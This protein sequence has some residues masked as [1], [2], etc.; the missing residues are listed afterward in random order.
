M[1]DDVHIVLTNDDQPDALLLERLVG[2]A[3][4]VV[5]N[6][7]VPSGTFRRTLGYRPRLLRSW[8]TRIVAI[9]S[10]VKPDLV[11]CYGANLNAYA[12]SEIKRQLGIPY[13]V[14]LHI[15][16]DE[17]VRGRAKGARNRLQLHALRALERHA[18]RRADLVLPVY[19]PIVPYLQ[20][21]GVTRYR[22]AY[23]VLN[24][25]H[26]RR[27]SEYSL[28]DPVRVISVGRQFAAK[29]PEQLMRAVGSLPN[30]QLTL[31]GDGPFHER[32]KRTAEATGAPQQF[33]FHRGLL[34]DELCE[35]L[36]GQDV[37]ATHSDFWELSKSVI[38]A[39][40][41]GLPVLLNR[42]SGAPVPE[43]TP[44]IASLVED[45]PDS[46]ARALTTLIEDA[47]IREQLGR[48]GAA[49]AWRRWAPEATEAAFVEI[50]RGL[51]SATVGED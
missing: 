10:A 4:V 3:R 7:P 47:E 14:S 26:L 1:F 48:R 2:R 8:A 15:N 19:E 23:N 39:V 51:L 35:L 34:N 11:R 45:R 28:H 43:L 17:D 24:G 38:E 40:L 20:R 50:Y 5:H 44:E 27:K 6:S 30:V 49:V 33:V 41:T 21:L 46:W 25:R 13:A 16:P 32:L 9:A 36:T 31:V 37:F 12:A 42:R 29:N 18:L 22:V